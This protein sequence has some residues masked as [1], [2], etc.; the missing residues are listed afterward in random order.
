MVPLAAAFAAAFG[1][2]EEAEARAP[3]RDAVLGES[4]EDTLEVT[5]LDAGCLTD[6]ATFA[7][8]SETREPEPGTEGNRA[9]SC[10]TGRAGG[11][12][13][14]RASRAAGHRR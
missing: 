14:D 12:D 5:F 13:I 6:F 11:R 10:E 1:V 4:F 7:S 8:L 2:D 3:A 9:A